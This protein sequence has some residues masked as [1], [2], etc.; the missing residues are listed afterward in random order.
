MFKIIM[1][2]LAIFLFAFESRKSN[3]EISRF[4][5]KES[6]WKT[7]SIAI[8]A[9][10]RYKM[11]MAQLR[12]FWIFGHFAFGW[13]L[14]LLKKIS[15]FFVFSIQVFFKTEK[16]LLVNKNWEQKQLVSVINLPKSAFK[17][18]IVAF[19]EIFLF[20]FYFLSQVS[21]QTKILNSWRKENWIFK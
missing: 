12:P 1:R 16:N 5:I 8:S 2:V 14:E 19:S 13:L 6:M 11:I 18:E 10:S 7:T 3:T 21:T 4:S 15:R 9:P 17:V 20:V